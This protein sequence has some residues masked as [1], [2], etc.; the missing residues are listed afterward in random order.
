MSLEAFQPSVS[1]V[2][3]TLEAARFAGVEGGAVS[4]HAVVETMIAVFVERLPAAS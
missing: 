3:D 1:P 4:G 2:P